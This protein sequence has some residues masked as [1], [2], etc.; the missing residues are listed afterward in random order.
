M[1]NK[2]DHLNLAISFSDL[3]RT[4][5]GP[6]GMNK[7]IIDEANNSMI[8]TNDGANIIN[9]VKGGH[10]I[11]ELFKS[12]AKSQE[13]A[14]GDG[15]T[16]A[17]ILAGQLL[18]N[19]LTL[20][21]KGLHP[22][23]IING[24]NLAKIE[25][26]KF[27]EKSKEPGDK[28]KIIKTAF[29]T[30]LTS[31]II[32]HLTKLVLK[33]KD[34]ENLQVFKMNNSNPLESELF[35]GTIFEGFTLNDRM[36]SEVTG[37]IAVLDFP[38]SM[39]YDN[40]QITSADELKKAQNLDSNYKK[41]IADKLK[42]L[43]IGCVFYTDTTPEFETFLT[44]YGITGVVVNRRDN[45]DAIC[46]AVKAT[47]VASVDQIDERHTGNGHV[48]YKKGK[49]GL[50]YVDGEIE[51]LVIKGS[52][53]QVL[54]EIM[55]ALDD[56]ISLLRHE[57]DMV[58]GAGAIEIEVANH[59]RE[60]AK[61]VGGKEQLA[62]EKYCE[63]VESIPLILAENCGLDAIEVLTTLKTLHSSGQKDMGVDIGIGISNARERCIFE[64]VLIKIHAINSATNVA[65]LIL[66]LDKILLGNG[67]TK[68]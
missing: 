48:K 14:I 43:D 24:Y 28:E 68:K 17:T 34:Y 23:T 40:F 59:L 66:K 7:M 21:N 38:V 45:I 13:E 12:L 49:T 46:N 2:Y 47:S 50:I 32:T 41:E 15:T 5:L 9:S 56:V 31:D 25:S 27:L 18:Q 42:S 6:R 29:G 55:R 44:D 51:T 26:M 54:D 19:A 39:K 22:T 8:M 67:E 20:L 53:N 57:L 33:V 58:I 37:K 30:K 3:V 64:P 16:T 11:M 35:L 4:T 65:N 10:P 62:I 60:F 61:Q 52:T 36:K 1:D 63:A